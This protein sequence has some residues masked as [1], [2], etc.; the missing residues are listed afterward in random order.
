MKLVR[1]APTRY[2]PV[3]Q[4]RFEGSLFMC[5]ALMCQIYSLDALH[6]NLHVR[7]ST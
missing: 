2:Q 7:C 4:S 3:V 1:L 5:V 6:K